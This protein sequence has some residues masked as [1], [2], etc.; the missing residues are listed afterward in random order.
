MPYDKIIG[1]WARQSMWKVTGVANLRLWACAGSVEPTQEAYRK[2]A[3]EFHP[4][5][6]SAPDA[7]T[8]FR[9]TEAMKSSVILKARVTID[10]KARLGARRARGQGCLKWT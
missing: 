3:M 1:W 9:D 6:N 7:D 4:D 8:K 5:R 10:G 2:L